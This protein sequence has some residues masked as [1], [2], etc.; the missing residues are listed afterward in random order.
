ML[1]YII[2]ITVL[3]LGIIII[4]ALSNGKVLHK[5]QY[6]FWIVIPLYMIL[7]PFIKIDVS[8]ADI[9]NTMFV[10]K[11]V[12]ATYEVADNDSAVVIIEDI[13]TEQVISDNL[14]VEEPETQTSPELIIEHE[15]I[16]NNHTASN[17]T[18]TN[19]KKIESVIVKISYCVSA[20]LIVALIAYNLGF[21]T[22][23][24]RNSNYIGI[25]STS[26]LKIYSIR[27]K[28]TPFLLINKIYI[29]NDSR[30]NEYTICH[31]ACHYKHGDY[32]WVLLRYL[33]LFLN[34]YNPIIWIAFILSGRD[35][36]YACD[37][38]VMKTYGVDSSKEYARTLLGIPQQ[39]SNTAIFT[40]STGLRGGYKMMKKRIINIKK[41]AKLS[42]KASALS[43][44]AILLVTSCSFVNTSKT[45]R[46]ITKDDPWFE[47]ELVDV[48]VKQGLNPDRRLYTMSP[49]LAGADEKYIVVLAAGEYQVND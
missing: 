39:Q 41:P 19:Q 36:E 31:E 8:V 11:N 12:T 2:G 14:S 4:R 13:P 21:I 30:N 20:A 48:D 6:A 27:H 25:D 38:E 3:T 49:K 26:G 7:M 17:K 28:G 32:I 44:A 45:A 47:G 40:L 18:R 10:P 37:E 42:R 29:D 5:H 23:C 46:K 16:T 35:C 22:Y 1:H 15:Q 24:K 9:W 34:W 43:M 33:V